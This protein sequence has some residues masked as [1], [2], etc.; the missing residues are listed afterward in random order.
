MPSITCPAGDEDAF[1]EVVAAGAERGFGP[2]GQ[3]VDDVA[4]DEGTLGAQV[5]HDPVAL[6]RR[7][8]VYRATDDTDVIRSVEADAAVDGE[9]LQHDVGAEEQPD[10]AVDHHAR[11]ATDHQRRL[12]APSRGTWNAA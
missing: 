7:R 4:G 10:L 11:P 9:I 8:R 2:D 5:A 12:G 3:A 1:A 6:R